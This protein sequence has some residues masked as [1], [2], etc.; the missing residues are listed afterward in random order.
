MHLALKKMI[1]K[2]CIFFF[3]VRDFFDE[4]GRTRIYFVGVLIVRRQYKSAENT[5]HRKNSHLKKENYQPPM[6]CR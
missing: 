6:R 5:A 4:H 1:C 3:E 2:N